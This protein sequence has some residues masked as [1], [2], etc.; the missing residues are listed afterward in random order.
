MLSARM[1]SVELW[2][3]ARASAK[4]MLYTDSLLSSQ[5]SPQ[6]IMQQGFK[7]TL[8]TSSRIRFSHTSEFKIYMLHFGW[9][10]KKIFN[11]YV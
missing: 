8:H 1:F 5:I 10:V 6:I 4:M 11:K 7:Q 3:K 2:M 9:M